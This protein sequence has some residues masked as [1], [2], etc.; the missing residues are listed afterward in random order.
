MKAAPVSSD[1]FSLFTFD[2]L[3]TWAGLA[4]VAWTDARSAKG[5]RQDIPVFFFFIAS[6]ENA[7]WQPTVLLHQTF[8]DQMSLVS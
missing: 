5:K 1:E 7:L 6:G 2:H 8:T 4:A 3:F